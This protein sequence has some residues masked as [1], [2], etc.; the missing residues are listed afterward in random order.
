[1]S[2][3]AEILAEN[4]RLREAAAAH[5]T[6]RARW[7]TT[8]AERES[9]RAHSQAK[10]DLLERRANELER[11]LSLIALKRQQP[12]SKRF[13]PSSQEAFAFPG[14]VVVPPR[15]AEL[16]GSDNDGE[17]DTAPPR[18]TP[19]KRRK[20]RRRDLTKNTS[21]P[22]RTVECPVEEEQ[23]CV[24]CGKALTVIGQ[25][26]SCRVEWV[27]GHFVIHDVVR[28]KCAC[29]DCPGEGVLTVPGPYAVPRALCANG[30]LARV[31]V[32]KFADHLPLH[33]Q[34]KRMAREGLDIGTNTLAGWVGAAAGLLVTIAKAI[35]AEMASSLFLLADDTG[36]PV[37]DA[38][39]GALRKGRLWVYTDQEQAV[40]RFSP[41]KAG[42]HPVADLQEFNGELLL[43]DGGSEFNAAVAEYSLTRAGCWS[44][45]RTYFH[46]A[47]HT[48]P[49]EAAMAMGTIC[50]L[51]MLEREVAGRPPAEVLTRRQ[52]ESR[53]LVDGFFEWVRVLSTIER[54]ESALGAAVRY[55]LNQ[56]ERLRTFLEHPELPIHNN[57]SEFLLRQPVVGR[58]NWLFSRSEGGAHG[59]AV[60]YTI[61]G[62]CHLQGLDPHAYLVD[63]LGRLDREP[64]SALTPKAWRQRQRAR[65]AA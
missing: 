37:Q 32:D 8:K 40:Y 43:V 26:T 49:N 64:A 51:F 25:A 54:P 19:R 4:E 5:A 35:W 36:H 62:S 59:A 18:A 55:A 13:V 44:H 10:I 38:G 65:A 57:L 52:R 42:E 24:R 45:L 29:R 31:L 3:L 33:R 12:A 21:L 47:R 61:I 41:T 14:D 27:P 53:G 56:E 58:K 39:N 9:E 20:P 48:H 28:D 6:E 7:E 11:T 30:L 17:V 60:H 22:R 16:E 63:V 46:D 2:G 34:A 23:A 15:R 1:M 50:D